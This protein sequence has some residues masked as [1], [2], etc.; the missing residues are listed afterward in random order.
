MTLAAKKAI[1]GRKRRRTDANG[2]ERFSPNCKQKAHLTRVYEAAAN[3]HRCVADL[4]TPPLAPTSESEHA[5]TFI[6]VELARLEV[7]DARKALAGHVTEH[8]C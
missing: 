6:R 4:M 7:S 3:R 1:A 8:G 2:F 5:K